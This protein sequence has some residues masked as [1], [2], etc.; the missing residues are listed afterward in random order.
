VVGISILLVCSTTVQCS[1]SQNFITVFDNATDNTLV[2]VNFP[3]SHKE[4]KMCETHCSNTKRQ[5][6]ATC[7]SHIYY[8][9][10]VKCKRDICV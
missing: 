5:S 2:R 3:I 7:Q 4:R 9:I 8:V 6:P 1:A 10:K